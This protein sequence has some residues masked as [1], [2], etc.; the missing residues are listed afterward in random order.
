MVKSSSSHLSNL[1]STNSPPV[2]A[3]GPAGYLPGF[4]ARPSVHLRVLVHV[5]A[6]TLYNAGPLGHIQPKGNVAQTINAQ[7][8]ARRSVRLLAKTLYNAGPPGH[9]HSKDNVAQTINAQN[10]VRITNTKN[11]IKMKKTDDEMSNN[12]VGT[13]CASTGMTEGE[14]FGK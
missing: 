9:I 11:T 8:I 13:A 3:V 4:A 6:K 12:G 5:L 1:F 2:Q 10:I 14:D 7:T